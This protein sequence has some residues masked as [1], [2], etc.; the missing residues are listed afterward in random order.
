MAAGQDDTESE[1]LVKN[2]DLEKETAGMVDLSDVLAAGDNDTGSS[3]TTIASGTEKT[4]AVDL[5]EDKAIVV[6]T[7]EAPAVQSR[8]QSLIL[9]L[10]PIDGKLRNILALFHRIIGNSFAQVLSSW[11]WLKKRSLQFLREDSKTIA[12]QWSGFLTQ[13]INSIRQELTKFLSL[14]W[15]LK[16][17]FL[18]SLCLLILIPW[19]THKAMRGEILPKSETLYIFDF[20]QVADS[21]VKLEGQE[22]WE[23]FRN[24]LR[25]PEYVVRF[26]RVI[27]ML[28][29]SR[30][31]SKSSMGVFSL[32]YETSSQEAATELKDR[33]AEVRD[34]TARTLEEIEYDEIRQP[35]GKT[36]A[37]KLLV[38]ALN[39]ILNQGTVTRIY[40]KDLIVSP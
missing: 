23:R 10:F 27:V 12:K 8:W 39:K 31:S 34:I 22:R 24:P 36:K 14:S 32:F 7:T 13:K 17:L 38:Q 30:F 20:N 18:F 1:G 29:A 5:F 16:L 11:E 33:E 19:V 21:V 25:Y 40:F 3:A 6:D 15:K 4:E 28:K 2:P 37:K 26:D 9:R 35:E